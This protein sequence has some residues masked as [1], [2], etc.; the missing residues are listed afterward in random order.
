MQVVQ[1]HHIPDHLCVLLLCQFRD[2]VLHKDFGAALHALPLL[3]GK[4]QT[5]D[6]VRAQLGPFHQ[7]HFLNHYAILAHLLV[8][9]V[10]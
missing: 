4:V 6:S 9:P 5:S 3:L 1:L 2:M 8:H 7:L 10:L